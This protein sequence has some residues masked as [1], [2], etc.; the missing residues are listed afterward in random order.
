MRLRPAGSPGS[1]PRSHASP[2]PRRRRCRCAS[3]RSPCT[4][5][6]DV[7]QARGLEVDV[8]RRLA[9][10]DL[11]GGDGHAEE[12]Q[13]RLSRARDRSAHGSTTT[14]GRAATA[15][16][17]ARPPPAHPAG[18]EAALIE[19]GQPCDDLLRYLLRRQLDAE[20]MWTY[21]D[22]SGELIPI[23]SRWARSCQCPPCSV[24]NSRRA[25]SQTC[26]ESIST[27]S[28]SKMTA[29]VM[30]TRRRRRSRAR[31][32]AYRARDQEC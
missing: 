31:S 2:P 10:R 3:P 29:S 4:D 1:E 7:E 25:S 18:G 19:A 17:S 20:L 28:R 27:P 12:V 22:H 16:R 26:S 6:G 13:A 5:P 15:L 14:R 24:T 32:P 21:C 11:L 9:A 8:R 30:T 23:M